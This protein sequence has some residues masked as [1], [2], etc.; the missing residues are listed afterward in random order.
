MEDFRIEKSVTMM[1]MEFPSQ[2]EYIDA[3]I[4]N[5]SEFVILQNKSIDVFGLKLVLS[6]GI[7]N[8]V[9]HGN[10]EDD[11]RA[12]HVHIIL[13][14][15]DITIKI[16]DM[17]NGFTWKGFV[18]PEMSDVERT[19]GRGF[20]LMEAYGYSVRFNQKGNTIYI[21]KKLEDIPAPP[22]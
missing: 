1:M 15:V 6:E 10:K 2:M 4:K 18:S 20:S 21:F 13:T 16:K 12:I 3:A 7:T 8:A 11:A 5:T 22:K 14:A 19:S 17:G 9:V